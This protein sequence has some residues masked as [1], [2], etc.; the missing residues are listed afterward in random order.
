MI[1]IRLAN[2]TSGSITHWNGISMEA[3][4][5]KKMILLVFVLYRTKTHAAIAEISRIRTVAITVIVR[6]FTKD[7]MYSSASNAFG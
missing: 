6:E 4:N 5:R 3:A 7:L 1:P 2:P